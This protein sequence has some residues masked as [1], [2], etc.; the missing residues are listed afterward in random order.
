M[1]TKITK[2]VRFDIPLFHTDDL[3]QIWDVQNRN[4]LRKTISRYI[5]TGYLTHV[6]RGF[7][8]L[9]DIEKIDPILLGATAIR[10]Y[11]Y[12]SCESVLVRAGII[13][14][15]LSA[16]T[17]VSAKSRK[18]TVLGQH[19]ISRQF[20]D[21]ILYNDAG[22]ELANGVLTASVER[23][24]ADMLYLDS[25]YYFDGAAMVDWKQVR[26]IQRKVGYK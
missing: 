22:V 6:Y 1:S 17:F 11:A 2:L 12:L 15:Q 4:T 5:A 19:Y 7:Y 25:G 3:G 10:D 9:Q 24:V 26:N 13:S 14:Q 8:A 18:S 21:S 23:A 20:K 16:E